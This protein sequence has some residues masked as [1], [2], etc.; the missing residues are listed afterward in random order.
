MDF[1][2]PLRMSNGMKYI[3][4]II[5]R[6]SHFIVL[7][8]TPTTTVAICADSIYNH[9][10]CSFGVPKFMTT[11]GGSSFTSLVMT[12]M[13]SLLDIKHHISAPHHPEGHG[14][15]ERTNHTVMQTV[16]AL[17]REHNHWDTLVR[18]AAFSIN[19]TVSRVLGVSL[20]F[21]CGPWIRSS[22]AN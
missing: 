1:I 17:F 13:T 20:S 12:E 5:D 10:I 7:V 3:L 2:G 16:R 4:N 14:A 21:C 6:V 19:T 9:W 22:L 11:D 15:V 18:P 8:P